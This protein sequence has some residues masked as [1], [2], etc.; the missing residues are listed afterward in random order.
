[1]SECE[2][3][4]NS[5]LCMYGK[6]TEMLNPI[7]CSRVTNTA[8]KYECYRDIAVDNQDSTICDNMQLGSSVLGTAGER[9]ILKCNDDVM[10]GTKDSTFN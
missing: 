3:S 6:A 8:L 5:D 9:A 7:V 10:S 2:N 4:K 1:M